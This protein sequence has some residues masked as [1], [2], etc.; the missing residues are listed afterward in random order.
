MANY[1][2]AAASKQIG[3]AEALLQ[4]TSITWDGDLLSKDQRTHLVKV[5]W[6]DQLPGGFN[7]I[8]AEGLQVLLD[9][10]LIA[11]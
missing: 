8:T 1:R 9:L 5:G 7:L 11:A 6:A 10:K 2:T 3:V 4:L